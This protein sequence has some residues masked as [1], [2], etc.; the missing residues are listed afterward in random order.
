MTKTPA[1]D[2]R[3]VVIAASSSFLALLVACGSDDA[4]QEDFASED[5]SSYE[6]VPAFGDLVLDG[7]TD[8][9]A[10]PGSPGQ[11]LVV[12]KGGSI[13]LVDE[14]SQTVNVVV[15]LSDRVSS[16]G[17]EEGLLSLALTPDFETSGEL[18]VYYSTDRP[19]RAI[20]SRLTF[21]EGSIDPASEQVILNKPHER[22]RHWGGGM[23]F[24]PDGNLFLSIG[25]G[26]PQGD[27]FGNA[28][29]RTDL[30]GSV[31][32]LTLTPDGYSIPD[33]NP[34]V[35]N[36]EGFREEVWVYGLRNPWR[37]SF[38]VETGR[39]WLAD[40]GHANWEEINIVE[41]GDNMGWSI[42]EGFECFRAET[43]Q[44]DGLVAPV[45]V[46]SHEEGCAII[47]GHV[48]QGA[49]MPE[50]RNHY[51]F[52]DYCAGTIWA[53]SE[54]DTEK[55]ELF[56][57]SEQIYAFGRAE[58]GEVLV[59]TAGGTIYRLVAADQSGNGGR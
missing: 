10:I 4:E 25:D 7:P 26:S 33:D 32:R 16:E 6:L 8:I 40:T 34:Y 21:Q 11:Y 13:K 56:D 1:W 5:P 23:E 29:D 49:D 37:L 3:L 57:S 18:L 20:L 59:L 12:E 46:Y 47:G 51:I 31:L 24:G 30:E 52:G 43:C 48:Y 38:D 9:E 55:I 41:G 58:N 39:L 54:G 19:R 45:A 27:E 44:E 2:C 36:S 50:L 15:D 28:Q 14:R 53:L 35:A 17:R 42:R 22:D